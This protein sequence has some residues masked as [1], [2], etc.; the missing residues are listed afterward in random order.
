MGVV[1]VAISESE[2]VE[3]IE[4]IEDEIKRVTSTTDDAFEKI[5]EAGKK[6]RCQWAYSALIGSVTVAFGLWRFNIPLA[7]ALGYI[8]V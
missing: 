7:T 3:S 8:T 1:D 5:D 6:V 4:K 2:L